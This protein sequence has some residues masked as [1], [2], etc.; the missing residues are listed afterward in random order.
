MAP[1]ITV[2]RLQLARM[3]AVAKPHHAHELRFTISE[4]NGEQVECIAP[5]TMPD[6]DTFVFREE[7]RPVR[8]REPVPVGERITSPGP[9]PESLLAGSGSRKYARPGET[10]WL[11]RGKPDHE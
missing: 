10:D 9:E 7:P 8:A 4:D 11:D 5:V 2:S 6:K 3:L 1:T